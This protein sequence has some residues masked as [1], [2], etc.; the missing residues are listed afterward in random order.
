M[1]INSYSEQIV[2]ELELGEDK[3]EEFYSMI[4]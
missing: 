3:K 1:I 2:D 4:Q